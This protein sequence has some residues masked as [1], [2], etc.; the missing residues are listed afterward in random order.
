MNTNGLLISELPRADASVI[1]ANIK[2]ALE[3]SINAAANSI[4]VYTQGGKVTLNGKANTWDDKRKVQ[5]AV[6]ASPGV[7]E[8][9]DNLAIAGL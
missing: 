1:V 7:T 8:V 5:R 4:R 6:W 2:R 3:R 9:E